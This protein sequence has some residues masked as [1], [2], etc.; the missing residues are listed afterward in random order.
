VIVAVCAECTLLLARLIQDGC[1]AA[2][3]ANYAIQANTWAAKL[4]GY[5][6]FSFLG[7]VL[8]KIAL[9]GLTIEE[10]VLVGLPG[11]GLGYLLARCALL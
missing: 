5:K 6:I 11:A 4:G 7:G 2:G 9:H 10:T 3:Y 8:H 1:R